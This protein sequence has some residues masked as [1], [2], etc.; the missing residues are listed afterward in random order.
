M[1]VLGAGL[2]TPASLACL[3]T[4]LK[5][6]CFCME[7][8]AGIAL[9]TGGPAIRLKNKNKKTDEA[10]ETSL[11]LFG[12]KASI[13]W[14]VV[15]N[16]SIALSCPFNMSQLFPKS[17]LLHFRPRYIYNAAWENCSPC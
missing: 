10:H 8:L 16:V 9:P 4:P 1:F 15:R 14:I 3:S 17:I 6:I 13:C 12:L 5:A 7:C 11:I 2:I